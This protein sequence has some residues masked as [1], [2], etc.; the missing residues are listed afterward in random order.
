MAELYA[1]NPSQMAYDLGVAVGVASLMTG[2]L[3]TR[4]LHQIMSA[5]EW[6]GTTHHER[7]STSRHYEPDG[8]MRFEMAGNFQFDYEN[9]DLAGMQSDNSVPPPP[10]DDRRDSPSHHSSMP[11]QHPDGH[12][13]VMRRPH[14]PQ[15]GATI[16]T[17]IEST[18]YIRRF[19]PPP[20]VWPGV[21][22]ELLHV[23]RNDRSTNNTSRMNHAAPS[24]NSSET[25]SLI[26]VPAS[27][28]SVNSSA[29]EQHRDNNDINSNNN[30]NNNS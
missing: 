10:P 21:R 24:R 28:L 23:D 15:N 9:Y 29:S 2:N 13:W 14:E 18:R 27:I 17:N 4:P 1:R 20:R 5:H 26:T 8:S 22:H 11:N 6:H 30:D 25:D 19:A 12:P 7:H 16:S 3:N